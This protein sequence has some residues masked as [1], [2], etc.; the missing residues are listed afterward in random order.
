MVFAVV[1][2]GGTAG[3]VVPAMAIL[4]ALEDAGYPTDML[5]YVGTKRG[6]EN[7]L[8]KSSPVDSAFLPISGLQRSWHPTKLI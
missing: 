2:G 8:M 4:E 6:I 3:H 7:T 5:R 1:T